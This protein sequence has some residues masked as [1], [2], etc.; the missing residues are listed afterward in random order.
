VDEEKRLI[1]GIVLQPEVVDAQ[2]DI[3][4]SDVIR[5][6]AH[7]FLSDYNS[8]TKMGLQHKEFPNGIHLV[9]SWVTDED[10]KRGD[11]IV[12]AGTWLIKVWVEHDGIW[13]KVKAGGIR[14]F[15]IGGMAK[16]KQLS[17]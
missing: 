2:G 16:V 15:S 8:R 5:K 1:T 9:E 12:K 6:A 13:G 17:A 7:Q 4:S 3:I 14:G 10:S 11:R